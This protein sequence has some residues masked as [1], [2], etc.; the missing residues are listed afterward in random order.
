MIKL[1]SPYCFFFSLII[2]ISLN[3]CAQAPKNPNLEGAE[4]TIYKQGLLYYNVVCSSCHLKDG[5]GLN[6]LY[7]PLSGSDYL[8]THRGELACIIKNGM[9]QEIQVNGIKYDQEMPANPR[10]SVI[11]ITN[12]LNYVYT[13]WDNDLPIT[14]IDQTKKDLDKCLD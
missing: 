11:D 2:L 5:T 4:N 8:S 1:Y 10:L 9:N 7:P 14:T 13:S 3:S 12:I 6:K